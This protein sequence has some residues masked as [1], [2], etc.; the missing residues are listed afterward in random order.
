LA[1]PFEIRGLE[2]IRKITEAIAR[3]LDTSS[4]FINMGEY[5]KLAIKERTAR[6]VDVF[7]QSFIP[8]SA[9]HAERRAEKG[10]PTDIVDLF[11]TGSMMA[12][13]TYS[14]DKEKLTMF[15]APSVDETGMSNPEKAFYLHQEREFFEMNQNDIEELQDVALIEINRILSRSRR[16]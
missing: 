7:G 5:L 12:N 8:Y 10:L 4:M 15:F 1:D 6:G 13:M 9:S 11:F 16:F 14:Y 3:G 2:A